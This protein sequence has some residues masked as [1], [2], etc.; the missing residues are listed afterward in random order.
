MSTCPQGTTPRGCG[1]EGRTLA[2]ASDQTR[3]RRPHKAP[4]HTSGGRAS[5]GVR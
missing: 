2:D 1:G 5:A 4:G 3:V